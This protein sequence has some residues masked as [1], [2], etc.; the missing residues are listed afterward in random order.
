MHKSVLILTTVLSFLAPATQAEMA[1]P[2]PSNFKF[3]K[4][5]VPPERENKQ[6]LLPNGKIQVLNPDGTISERFPIIS[7]NLQTFTGTNAQGLKAPNTRLLGDGKIK[8]AGNTAFEAS[9]GRQAVVSSKSTFLN[10]A[11][12]VRLNLAKYNVIFVNSKAVSASS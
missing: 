7:E 4:D 5:V 3:K 6:I 11:D 12:S 1:P 8:V 10:H 2:M 9:K